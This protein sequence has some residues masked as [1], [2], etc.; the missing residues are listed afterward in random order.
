MLNNLAPDLDVCLSI[1]NGSSDVLCK[2]SEPIVYEKGQDLS[3][4]CH[5]DDNSGCTG[6]WVNGQ[7]V[8]NIATK[9]FILISFLCE[10]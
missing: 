5:Y 3:S 4:V 8:K 10:K 1:Y 6:K 2:I 7:G 9:S